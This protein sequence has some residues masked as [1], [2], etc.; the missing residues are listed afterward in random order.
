MLVVVTDFHGSLSCFISVFD[1]RLDRNGT[2]H[3]RP[4]S[5]KRI[6]VHEEDLVCWFLLWI[7]L[8]L[9]IGFYTQV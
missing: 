3:M 1:S 7:C 9:K 4:L 8:R 6:D 5:S 2:F